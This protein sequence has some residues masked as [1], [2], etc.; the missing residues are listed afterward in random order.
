MEDVAL[1]ATTQKTEAAGSRHK[2]TSSRAFLTLLALAWSPDGQSL[3]SAGMDGEVHVCR[4]YNTLQTSTPI[5]VLIGVEGV[6]VSNAVQASPTRTVC[7]I[8][9]Y[10]QRRPEACVLSCLYQCFQPDSRTVRSRGP[11]PPGECPIQD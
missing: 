8:A 10:R 2:V 7:P 4:R 6:F 9:L 11:R 3:A 5:N 1:W